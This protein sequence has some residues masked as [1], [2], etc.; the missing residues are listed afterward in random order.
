M[1]PKKD[2]KKSNWKKNEVQLLIPIFR[3]KRLKSNFENM[4]SILEFIK[5][6]IYKK[7]EKKQD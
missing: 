1:C 6:K 7:L 3:A 5:G 4:D 2:K